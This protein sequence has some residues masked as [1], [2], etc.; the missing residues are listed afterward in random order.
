M[1]FR[2][3]LPYRGRSSALCP[4]TLTTPSHFAAHGAHVE[5]RDDIRRLRDDIVAASLVDEVQRQSRRSTAIHAEVAA[6]RAVLEERAARARAEA[7]DAVSAS[8]RGEVE[9]LRETCDALLTREELQYREAERCIA[10]ESDVCPTVFAAQQRVAQLVRDVARLKSVGAALRKRQRRR[11]AV[12]SEA[13]AER[14]GACRVLGGKLVSA[15]CI[16][17]AVRTSHVPAAAARALLLLRTWCA[18]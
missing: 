9:S 16:F 4:L 11:S 2:S 14:S 5:L 17:L 12:E 3:G 1:N 15:T 7:E 8:V 13:D 18:A 6:L 10:G